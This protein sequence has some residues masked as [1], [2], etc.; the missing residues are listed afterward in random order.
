[1]AT[2]R[3]RKPNDEC[4]EHGC[5]QREELGEIKARLDGQESTDLRIEAAVHQLINNHDAEKK[6]T[7]KE[8]SE[9]KKTCFIFFPP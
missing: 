3:K 5:I 2:T 7:Y 9:F 8:F 1:M 4:F 6:A